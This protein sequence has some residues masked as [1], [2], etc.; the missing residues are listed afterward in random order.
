MPML[1]IAGEKD[2]VFKPQSIPVLVSQMGC[3][4]STSLNILKGKGHLL[5]E[6]QTVDPSIAGLIDQW[7]HNRS[8]QELAAGKD[9]ISSIR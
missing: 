5:L 6:H 8:E 7:L 2:A 1:I 3:A 9:N 4:A